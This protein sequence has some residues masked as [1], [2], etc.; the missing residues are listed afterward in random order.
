LVLIGPWHRSARDR[1]TERGLE[2]SVDDAR[3]GHR[4]R[5]AHRR[6]SRDDLQRHR[7]VWSRDRNPG[8]REQWNDRSSSASNFGH[9]GEADRSAHDSRRPESGPQRHDRHSSARD[10]AIVAPPAHSP[11]CRENHARALTRRPRVT[12]RAASLVAKSCVG[13][14]RQ[15]TFALAARHSAMTARSSSPTAATSRAMATG[16][17]PARMRSRARAEPVR[18]SKAGMSSTNS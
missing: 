9:G 1:M 14:H 17:S 6:A 18:R 2:V 10:V 15:A 4:K 5:V 7:A 11:D 13:N 3:A 16:S 8:R 12:S